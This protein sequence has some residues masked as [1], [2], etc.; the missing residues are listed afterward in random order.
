MNTT[1]LTLASEDAM[2]NREV[3]ELALQ[4]LQVTAEESARGTRTQAA[5]RA[6]AKRALR[7]ALGMCG[8]AAVEA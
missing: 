4:A 8:E 1:Q 7:R 2:T 5:L 3:M 6:K